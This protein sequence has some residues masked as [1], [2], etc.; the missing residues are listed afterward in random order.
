MLL[1]FRQI[2]QLPL[3]VTLIGL[4]VV[5]ILGAMISS[6]VSWSRSRGPSGSVS[7]IRSGTDYMEVEKAPSGLKKRLGTDGTQRGSSARS[8]TFKPPSEEDLEEQEA[9][10]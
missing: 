6:L 10:G 8:V 3:A 4:A 5:L 9:I 2:A 7:R 1:P